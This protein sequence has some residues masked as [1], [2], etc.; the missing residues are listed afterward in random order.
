MTPR[1]KKCAFSYSS[2]VY[3]RDTGTSTRVHSVLQPVEHFI[4]WSDQFITPHE[5]NCLKRAP[6]RHTSI[7]SR[8][9]VNLQG[10][11]RPSTTSQKKWGSR[12]KVPSQHAKAVT[13]R[14]RPHEVY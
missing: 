9:T 7:Q 4:R 5:N 6:R 13:P 14:P 10:S 8:P 3:D 12:C 11:R 2:V 1:E